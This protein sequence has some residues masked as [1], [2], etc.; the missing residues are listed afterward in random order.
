[1]NNNNSCKKEDK[2][3]GLSLTDIKLI[4]LQLLKHGINAK[5]D[6]NR[7]ESPETFPHIHN[8]HLKQ[9]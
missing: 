7:I 5:L 4:K 3:R 6:K 2:M 1:M 8:V 9:H